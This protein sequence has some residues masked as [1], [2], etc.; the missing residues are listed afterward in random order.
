MCHH[1]IIR[2]LIDIDG[3]RSQTIYYCSKCYQ[4]FQGRGEDSSKND[5]KR[6]NKKQVR[7]NSQAS[8]NPY[9]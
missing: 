1:T 3:D 4:C 8:A 7:T 6:P 5:S 2:D 9:T